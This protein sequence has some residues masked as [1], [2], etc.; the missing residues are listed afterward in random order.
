[1]KLLNKSNSTVNIPNVLSIARILI[2]PFFVILIIKKMFFS[3]LLVFTI[4]G[5]SDAL[6]GI[7]ARYFNQR[8]VLGS[9]LDPLADKIL[10]SSAF[11]SLAILKAIPGWLAVIVIT[12][13]VLI[14]LG[15]AMVNIMGKKILIKPSLVSKCTT[16][17]QLTA[18]FLILLDNQFA[19]HKLLILWPLYWITAFFTIISGLHYIITGLKMLQE[20]SI[21]N[22]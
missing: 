5:I 7:I 20:T 10:L 22:R 12:R 9:Y 18:I 21:N 14:L 2:T 8:T 11:I 13:D 15:I 1:M 3:A 17:F 16:V 6:D 19:I 4:A